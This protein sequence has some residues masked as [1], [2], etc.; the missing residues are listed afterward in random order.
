MADARI[1][2]RHKIHPVRRKVEGE[3]WH[4]DN[5]PGG[6][7]PD[8]CVHEHE[9]PIGRDGPAA[10]PVNPRWSHR[11][12]LQVVEDVRESDRF[13]WRFDPPRAYHRRK[14]LDQIPHHLKRNAS[15]PENDRSAQLRDVDAGGSQ[16]HPNLLPGA[17]VI[18]QIA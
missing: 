13:D 18:R 7:A 11:G 9:L 16:R 4:V 15:G 3:Q 10:D 14:P 5:Q 2:R 17:Q 8:A 6:K 1:Y 12:L